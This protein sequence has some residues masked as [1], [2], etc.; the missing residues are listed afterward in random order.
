MLRCLTG[1]RRDKKVVGVFVRFSCHA[2]NRGVYLARR[3]HLDALAEA[4]AAARNGFAELS[5][6]DMP[7]LAKAE[8]LHG[9]SNAG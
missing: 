1:A 4:R 5:D 6:G 7:E 9:F 8:E 2:S 3:R